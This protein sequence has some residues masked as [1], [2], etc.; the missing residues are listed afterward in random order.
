M[1][2]MTTNQYAGDKL[3]FW[4]KFK[5]NRTAV[6]GGFML[7]L[8]LFVAIASPW[9]TSRNPQQTSSESF[10]PPSAQFLFGTDDLGRDVFSGVVYGARSSITVGI[11]VALLSGFMGTLVGLISGYAGGRLDDLLMRLT[12]LFLIPPRFFLALVAVALFGSS[13]Y[14]LIGVLAIT[15]WPSTARLVRSQ[16]IS[17]K[18][19]SFVEAARAIGSGHTRIMFREI[20]PNTLPI[21]VTNLTLMV[22]SVVLVEASLE[23]LGL[24]NPNQISWG[25]MLHNGQHFMRD[26]W[27]M[28]FFPTLAVCMLV[29]ALNVVGD[30][31]ND[32]LDPK[33]R[34]EKFDKP[35]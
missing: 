3:D 5:Q 35:A 21:I 9:I 20:L 16:V 23:F 2:A 18:E 6:A 32:A 11:I 12:E 30:A 26:A 14:T 10:R 4:R 29:F 34:I 33:S 25:Y 27:W 7:A 22:G 1:I 28:L 15:Y 24:G 31:L 13:F 17:L 8:M 19:R